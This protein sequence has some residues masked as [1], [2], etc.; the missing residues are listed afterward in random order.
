MP[1]KKKIGLII[2]I[3]F[4]A[5]PLL[6]RYFWWGNRS[7]EMVTGM[8]LP[9]YRRHYPLRH[10]KWSGIFPSEGGFISDPHFLL[11]EPMPFPG[12]ALSMVSPQRIQFQLLDINPFFDDHS[13]EILLLL[14]SDNS[15]LEYSLQFPAMQGVQASL[16]MPDLPNARVFPYDGQLAMVANFSGPVKGIYLIPL[17]L[18]SGARLTLISANDPQFDRI[19]T[20]LRAVG[21][22]GTIRDQFCRTSRNDFIAFYQKYC[23]PCE[24]GLTINSQAAIDEDFDKFWKQAN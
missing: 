2:L 8:H 11:S 22:D 3:A 21:Q 13:S 12:P 9:I 5:L 17:P 6:G 18:R 24:A 1:R 14:T 15:T 19:A 7:P 23:G 4:L 16:S 20:Q 10:W